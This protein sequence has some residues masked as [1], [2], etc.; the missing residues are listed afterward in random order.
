MLKS[1]RS[2]R[3]E[4][5]PISRTKSGERSSLP[6][7]GRQQRGAAGEGQTPSFLPE[8]SYRYAF[9]QKRESSI[10]LL[11]IYEDTLT[12][13]LKRIRNI[14]IVQQKTHGSSNGS[15]RTS[16]IRSSSLF[17]HGCIN[18]FLVA[19]VVFR[20]CLVPSILR[21]LSSD[22]LVG[23]MDSCLVHLCA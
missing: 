8:P 13:G 9:L 23:I 2:T 10:I 17:F 7:M 21:C 5:V 22:L 1:R 4:E 19:L 11:E 15:Q 18:F 3:S 12:F 20:V 6:A 16:P 14:C